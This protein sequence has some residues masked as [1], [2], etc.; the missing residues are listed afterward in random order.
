MKSRASAS[1]NLAICTDLESVEEI[2]STPTIS[3]WE[4]EEPWMAIL[5][6]ELGKSFRAF[7]KESGR[8]TR[9]IQPKKT[10]RIPSEG[11]NLQV[12]MRMDKVERAFHTYLRRKEELLSYIMATQPQR[13]SA[14]ARKTSAPLSHDTR[15]ELNSL[16]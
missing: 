4:A 13:R 3:D 1:V 14:P 11:F 8:L 10:C 7:A 9:L 12:A 5:V 2:Q 15:L 16:R 6:E